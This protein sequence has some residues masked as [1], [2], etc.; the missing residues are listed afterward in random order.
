MLPFGHHLI[1]IVFCHILIITSVTGATSLP[2]VISGELFPLEFRSLAS[3]F[4]SAALSINTF[5]SV[6]SFPY[7]LNTLGFQVTIFIHG[8]LVSYCLIAT[9]VVLPETKDKALQDIENELKGNR[10]VCNVPESTVPLTST[11]YCS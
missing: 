1:A 10:E 5:I 7:L 2:F 8:A 6:K 9:L 3:G 11:Q 4:S